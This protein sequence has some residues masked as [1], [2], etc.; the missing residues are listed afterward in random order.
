MTTGLNNS[1]NKP[2]NSTGFWGKPL[3]NRGDEATEDAFV[4]DSTEDALE[5]EPVK[6]VIPKIGPSEQLDQLPLVDVDAESP[7]EYD[8]LSDAATDDS[9]EES[10]RADSAVFVP[11]P[12]V[13]SEFEKDSRAGSVPSWLVTSGEEPDDGLGAEPISDGLD[14]GFG[15]GSDD[16]GGFDDFDDELGSTASLHRLDED[17][18]PSLGITEVHEA[19]SWD[20]DP[21]EAES[22]KLAK[23][24]SIFGSKRVPEYEAESSVYDEA[25]D[26]GDDKKSKRLRMAAIAG[27]VVLACALVY[28]LGVQHFSTRVLPR[29]YVS[30]LDIS[31]LTQEEAQKALEDDTANF[32]CTLLSGKFEGTISGSDISIARNEERVA[33]AAVESGSAY[34]WPLALLY[35]K[36]VDVD[37]EVTFDEGA[38]T[39]HVNDVVDDYNRKAVTSKDVEI[40]YD[41]ESGL[42]GLQGTASGKAVIPEKVDAAAKDCIKAFGKTCEMDTKDVVRKATVQDIPDYERVVERANR[43]RTTDIPITV[44]GETVITSDAYQNAQWVTIGEGPSV[45]VNEESIRWWAEAAVQYSVY[46]TDEWNYYYLDQDAF[47]QQLSERLASG[48][49]DPF[50]AP[51]VEERSTE[52]LSRDYAYE[53]GGWNPELGRYIDVDLEAQFA[54][55]FDENGEVIWESA[56]VTGSMYEGY[57]TV[58]GT[59]QIYSMEQGAVLVGFDYNN[60]GEPDY[61]SYVNYWMPFYGGFGL[62]DATWRGTFGGDLYLYDGSHGCVNLPYYKAQELFNL[63]FV[64]EV[65]NVHW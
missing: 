49:V 53:R 43:S 23:V 57:S 46:H 61:E 34:S 48:N 12:E 9:A 37:Q 13:V 2:S 47:V 22:S 32:A 58:T 7:Y 4:D 38:L 33:K 18:L 50:E 31:G 55:L 39:S 6:H 42:Y 59:F 36:E 28:G 35:G 29:T 3:V 60:D 27:S 51:T 8:E 56:T 25:E 17:G 26:L 30:G 21:S 44:N 45:V 15:D 10:P 11:V 20:S 62:H 40:T 14:D 16:L 63:T 24:L 41:E 65:V 1:N 52:G 19:L 54:R 64:G 5:A